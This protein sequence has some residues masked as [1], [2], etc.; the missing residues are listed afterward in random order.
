MYRQTDE[1]LTNNHHL[2][3]ILPKGTLISKLTPMKENK[4][5]IYSLY[6]FLGY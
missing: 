6:K 1:V 3:R 5:C 2:R 4:I